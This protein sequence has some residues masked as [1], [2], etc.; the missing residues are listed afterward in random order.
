MLGLTSRRSGESGLVHHRE[1][2]DSVQ[3]G[4]ESLV[5]GPYSHEFGLE[6]HNTALEPSH[7]RNDAGIRS[8]DVSED[9]FRHLLGSSTLRD[10]LVADMSASGSRT[11]WCTGTGERG[12]HQESH[13]K[14]ARSSARDAPLRMPLQVS[15]QIGRAG[16]EPESFSA[17]HEGESGWLQAD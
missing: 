11:R 6:L 17:E 4:A 9:C 14:R 5:L 8:T 10:Q 7:L 13:Q 15:G 3:L 2:F 16:R 12:M 1:E